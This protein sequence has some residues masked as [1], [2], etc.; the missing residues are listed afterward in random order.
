MDAKQKR[1]AEIEA[2][3]KANLDELKTKR[4]EKSLAFFTK[5][6]WHIIE[7]ET[8]LTWNWHLDV[9]C[10]YLEAAHARHITR[11]II[12]VPPGSLKSILVSV[13]FP[14][15]VWT[16][17]P[18]RRVLGI[19]NI[20]D[21]SIRDSARTKRIVTDEWYQAKWPVKLRADQSAKT[22]YETD[23][24][25][26]RLSLG[27]TGNITGKRGDIQLIDDP[28]D[29]TT[30][31][32][33]VQRQAVLDAY[34]TKLS[35]RIN[36]QTD[37]VIILI[38]QRLHHMDL[39]GHL[40]SKTKTKWV[41]V[42]IPMEYEK[43]L[44]YDP[45]KHLAVRL[46]EY[47]TYESNTARRGE[48]LKR[49]KTSSKG[50]AKIR[51]A[52]MSKEEAEKLRDPRKEGDLL[53]PQLFPAESVER[54]KEDYGEY[55]AAGQLQQRPSV[56]GGGILKQHWWRIW[57]KT[58]P[59]PTVDHVWISW[60][61]AYSEADMKNNSFSAYTMWGL[62]WNEDQQRDCMLLLEVWYDRIDYPE[63]RKKAKDLEA[64]KDRKPDCHLIEKKASGQSLIQDLRQGNIP[65]RAYSP[66]RDKITR[67]YTVQAMLESGQVYIPDRKWA[68]NFTY[69]LSTFPTGV[70]ESEDLTDTFTQACI[71]VKNHWYTTNPYDDDDYEKRK[72]YKRRSAYG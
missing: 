27:I 70:P 54:M 72:E 64:D 52:F 28:H 25:G 24:G 11:L 44:T 61:T 22:N 66:D 55:A 37:S 18:D 17:N 23:K 60:D 10:A 71:Y 57:D 30:A 51:P 45:V 1:L 50:V 15:W 69:L 33:D 34:D 39:A 8:E 2:Q 7:P 36:S 5:E 47:G 63:L 6:A 20:Q 40:L 41:H 38:M 59:L 13:M 48:I 19:S 35:S 58:T 46:N 14:A 53:F 26:F 56:K 32:S 31:Q 9:I 65:L 3:L 4:C 62:F 12:N 49:T 42:C 67:A 43:E 16:K 29:A 21:L 68:H